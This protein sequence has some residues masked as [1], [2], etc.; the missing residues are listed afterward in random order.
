M[1]TPPA[2][3]LK[4]VRR[5][6]CLNVIFSLLLQADHCTRCRWCDGT[7]SEAIIDAHKLSVGIKSITRCNRPLIRWTT[8]TSRPFAGEIQGDRLIQQIM[9]NRN[10]LGSGLQEEEADAVG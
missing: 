10:V 3:H 6:Y 8:F 4:M 7:Q 5:G 9:K 1:P 2:L